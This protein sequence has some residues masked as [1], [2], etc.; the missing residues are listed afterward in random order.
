LRYGRNA[1]AYS[2]TQPA[3]TGVA[4]TF[5]AGFLYG[6]NNSDPFNPEFQAQG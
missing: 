1:R 5:P 6:L 3:N 2:F 4:T